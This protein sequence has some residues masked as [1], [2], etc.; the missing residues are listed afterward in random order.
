MSTI[1][2]V[3]LAIGP[4]DRSHVDTLL[5]VVE[6]VAGPTGATVYLVHVFTHEEYN[7]LMGQMDAD[8]TT[9]DI[10]PDELAARQNDVRTPVSRLEEL[11]IDHEIRGVVGY[12]NKE[13]VKTA[14]ELG[15]DMLF[16]GGQHRSPSGKAI[17]GDSA[18]QILLNA[19]CPVTYVQRE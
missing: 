10:E 18:Q 7:E 14:N 11:R 12:P 4:N 2:S 16:I 17:F 5:D 9:E 15:V 8:P 19:A 3:L 6:S 1:E 13:I